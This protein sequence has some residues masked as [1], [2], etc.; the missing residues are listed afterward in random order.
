MKRFLV[1]LPIVLLVFLSACGPSEEQVQ[2]AIAQT[3]AAWTLVPTQ[4]DF[5]TYTPYPTY[6]PNAT[7]T[8]I[9]TDILPTITSLIYTETITFTPSITPT[10]T[11]TYTP[12][13]TPLPSATPDMNLYM[14]LSEFRA[15]YDRQTD[16]TRDD[17]VNNTIGKIVDWSG[18]VTDV[19]SDLSIIIHIPGTYMSDVT[20][21]GVPY[22]DAKN[23]K[24][25]SNIRFSGEFL[26]LSDFLGLHIEI[27]N[28]RIIK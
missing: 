1:L 14:S 9:P 22:E 24:K 21:Y 8:P 6:T 17:F 16:L 19:K 7:Y 15:E 28:G 13:K 11:I 12:T 18:E 3:Q 5:P 10:P 23:I 27:G 26:G 25:G 2:N 20:I 4:P